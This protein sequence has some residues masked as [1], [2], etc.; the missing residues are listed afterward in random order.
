[1]IRTLTVTFA[2]AALL[3]GCAPKPASRALL[4]PAAEPYTGGDL[5]IGLN[6]AGPIRAQTYFETPRLQE[7]FPQARL[8]EGVVQIDPEDAT[9]T[10]DVINVDQDGVRILEVDDGTRSAPGTD[11]PLI[12]QV[13][14]VGGPVRGPHGETLLT[15]WRDAR[16]DLTQCEIGQGHQRG[17]LVCARPHEGSVTYIFAIPGWDSTDLPSAWMLHNR[18]Y[19]REIVW[20]PPTTRGPS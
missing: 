17:R 13:R 2:L 8:A 16:F 7:L 9:D 10:I 3:A 11:D 18:A 4:S 6:G 20:T 12:G 5:I 1:M 15:P 14:G 19:L